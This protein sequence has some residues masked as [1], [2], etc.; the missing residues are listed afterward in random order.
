MSYGVDMNNY[1]ANDDYLMCENC[2]FSSRNEDL[3]NVAYSPWGDILYCKE[4]ACCGQ[5]REIIKDLKKG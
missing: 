4:C 2:G 5:C 1:P 3:F